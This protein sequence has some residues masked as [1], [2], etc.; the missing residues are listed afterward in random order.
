LGQGRGK[1]KCSDPRTQVEEKY[2]TDPRTFKGDARVEKY[3]HKTHHCV[4]TR[5]RSDRLK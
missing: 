5:N 1:D 3:A 4:D 2:H